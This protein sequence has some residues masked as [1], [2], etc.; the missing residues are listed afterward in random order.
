MNRGATA[1]KENPAKRAGPEESLRQ[2]Q[3]VFRSSIGCELRGPA[4]PFRRR[5]FGI[6]SRRWKH[7]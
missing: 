6:D 1:K 4:R 2:I 7:L 5:P 3:I